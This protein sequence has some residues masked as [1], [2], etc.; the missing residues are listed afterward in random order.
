MTLE[1]QTAKHHGVNAR[2]KRAARVS[3][4]G[5]L[6]GMVVLAI[7]GW[8][9]T[10]TGVIYRLSFGLIDRKLANTIHGITIV[11]LTVLFL[12]HIFINAMLTASPRRPWNWI[13]IS[14]LGIMGAG[15]MAIVVYLEFFRLGG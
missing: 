14:L 12:S 2:W 3:A 9:I 13:L 15:V 7:S 10:Q 6:I 11:P 1:N 5:L 4:W 8:G